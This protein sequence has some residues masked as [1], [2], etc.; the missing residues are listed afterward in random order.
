MIQLEVKAAIPERIADSAQGWVLYDGECPLCTGAA[1]RFTPFLL[2]HHFHLA[3]LQTPWVQQRLGLKTDGPLAEMK[4]L[5]G[6]GRIF[7]GAEALLQIARTIWWARPMYALAQIPGAM[8]LFRVI[9]RVIAANR[10]CSNGACSI[11][12]R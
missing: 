10:H 6:D 3:T 2:R 9:Y 12:K 5:A 4:L 11:Q 8:V 7:G 1:T